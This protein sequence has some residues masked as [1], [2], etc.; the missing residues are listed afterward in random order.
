MFKMTLRCYFTPER[1]LSRQ[2][3]T[4]NAG[5]ATGRK[6]TSYIVGRNVQPLWKSKKA[7]TTV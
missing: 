7:K 5:E 2:Q 6:G 4:M 1:Q 3:I